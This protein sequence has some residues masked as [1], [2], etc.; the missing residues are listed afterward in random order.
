MPELSRRARQMPAS[1]IR[2]LS[3]L[4]EAARQRG[5]HVYPLN[6][7]QPDI[8]TPPVFWKAIREADLRVL[9]YSPSE[10]VLP[11]RQAIARY[12]AALGHELTTDEVLV[13]T[14][15]SEALGFTF[16]VVM[17]PGDEL[18]VPEPFYANYL[19]F[20]LGRDARV[21]PVTCRIEND[22]GLPPVEAFEQMITSRTRAILICN[23]G[24]PTG[25]LYPRESLEKLREIVLRH[26]LYLVADEVYREFVYGGL[27]HHSVLGLKGLE[28]HAIVIDSTSKRFSACGARIGCVVSRN[29]EL[30][31]AVL[32]MAQARLSPPSLG[33][34]GATAMYA[35]TEDY[36]RSVNSEYTARRDLLHHGLNDIDGVLCP[37][38]GGAFYAMVRLPVDDA[39]DFCRWMLEEFSH[40]GA[41]VMMAPGEGFY[42]TEGLGRDEVRIAYVLKRDDL[43]ASIEC[44][45][46]ALT[47]YPGVKANASRRAA[48]ASPGG[49]G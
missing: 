41:T 19:S 49:G 32:R 23:P 42:A 18:I 21:V 5:V 44:L 45:R 27:E 31:D 8:E 17:N 4:A 22:F 33:Q 28:Q 25:A 11:L 40:N 38:V 12:Y 46:V 24:N 48:S 3:P 9:S 34:I 7:G 35:L 29:A 15:A 36:Y 14:G 39:E 2:K 1:P 47:R 30:M 37:A 16:A 6:I 20:C 13:T 43:M 10:G 26:D